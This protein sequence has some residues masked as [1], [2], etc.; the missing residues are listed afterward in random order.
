MTDCPACGN[1]KSCGKHHVYV[2]ELQ[3]SV[4]DQR[5]FFPDRTTL[6]SQPRCF[7]V[8]QTS[9]RPDC[10]YKQHVRKNRENRNFDCYCETGQPIRRP[11]T[12]FNRGNRFVRD[13]HKLGGLRPEL[14]SHLNPIYKGQEE[15][16]KVEAKLACE[17]ITAGHAVHFN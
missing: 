16:L 5:K 13:Y 15:A 17:L 6:S 11:F 1:K 8:G 3:P 14:F 4:L 12:A 9:H 7:Y 10:R 2:I